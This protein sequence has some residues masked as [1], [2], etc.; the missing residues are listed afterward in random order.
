MTRTRREE[1]GDETQSSHHCSTKICRCRRSSRRSCALR[2]STVPAIWRFEKNS[3]LSPSAKKSAYLVWGGGIDNRNTF[4]WAGCF[5]FG[6]CDDENEKINDGGFCGCRSHPQKP[7]KSQEE[8]RDARRQERL[9]LL[10]VS[11]ITVR[12][13]IPTSYVASYGQ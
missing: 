1:C 12:V 7:K 9:L 8:E 5:W 10:T 4:G 2:D 11:C 3:D 6:L 13:G